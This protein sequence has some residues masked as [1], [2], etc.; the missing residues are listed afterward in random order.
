MQKYYLKYRSLLFPAVIKMLYSIA[1]D[2]SKCKTARAKLLPAP[3]E[4]S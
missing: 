4:N 3:S 1:S 2:T